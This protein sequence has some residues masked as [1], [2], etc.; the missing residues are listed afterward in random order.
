MKIKNL[1]EVL[2]VLGFN[3]DVQIS[4]NLDLTIGLRLHLPEV[5]S[6]STEIPAV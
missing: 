2:P 6:C 1:E 4:N 5:L 3:R